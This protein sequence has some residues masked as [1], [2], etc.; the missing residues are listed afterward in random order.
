M[1]KGANRTGGDASKLNRTLAKKGTKIKDRGGKNLG[2]DGQEHS[3]IAKGNRTQRP[4][5]QRGR[6]R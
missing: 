6:Q 1:T 3:R 4:N 2:A 5:P